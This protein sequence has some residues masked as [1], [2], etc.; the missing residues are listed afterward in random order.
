MPTQE[1]LNYVIGIIEY[2]FFFCI[3]RMK[4]SKLSKE[5]TQNVQ[6]EARKW[7]II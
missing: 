5:K 7:D 3:S 4:R 6:F 1:I 2:T